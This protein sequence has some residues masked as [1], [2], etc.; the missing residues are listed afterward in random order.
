MDY[1]ETAV[2]YYMRLPTWSW[3]AQADIYPSNSTT[4]SLHD[5]QS[6]LAKGYHGYVPF[7]GCEGPRY[8]ET[9]EGEGSLDNGRV[10]L[11]EVWYYFY[12]FGRPQDGAWVPR[13]VSDSYVTSCT[14]TDG[15]LRYAERTES[16][17]RKD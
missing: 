2:R 13:N 9:Q 1:F 3:L 16:S 17:V 12:A 14:K 15:A 5:V 7:V 11:S 4:Y 10:F 8:N 6:A